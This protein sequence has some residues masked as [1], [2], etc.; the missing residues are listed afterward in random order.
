MTVLTVRRWVDPVVESVGQPAM[1][2]YVERYWLP[3]IGPSCMV[4]LRKL[5]LDLG[6]APEVTYVVEDLAASIGTPGNS[7]KGGP[8]LA[9]TIDR[10][11]RYRV[12]MFVGD[13][14]L[15]RTVLDRVP[16]ALVRRFPESLALEHTRLMQGA[17]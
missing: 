16:A 5:A 11:C 14:L 10:L 9:R 2:A 8:A 7:P 17:S 13:V 12:A 1:S 6:E 15:V 3:V 4:L